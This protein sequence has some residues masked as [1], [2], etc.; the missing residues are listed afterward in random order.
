ME[1]CNSRK[2]DEIVYDGRYC[3]LCEKIEEL[4][5]A[6]AKLSSLSNQ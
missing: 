4:E 5:E 2:H 3:P 6:N 1:I